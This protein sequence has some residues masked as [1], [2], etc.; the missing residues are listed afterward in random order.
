MALSL[1]SAACAIDVPQFLTAD[2]EPKTRKGGIQHLGFIKC[3][4]VF[5]DITD[6]AEWAAAVTAHDV[7]ITTEGVG[8]KPETS[9]TNIKLSS[10]RPETIS[11]ETHTIPFRTYATDLATETD[12]SIHN[13]VRNNI[14]KFRMFWIG[15][16]G[17][18]YLNP[19]YATDNAGFECSVSKWDYIVPEDSNE[20][21]Y[22]DIELTFTYVGIVAGKKLPNVFAELA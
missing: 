7:H 18:F 15:C 9:K 5:T 21:A 10:C 17:L 3:D 22:Y 14:G 6:E 19:D 2:C 13:Q 8:S 11:G 1:C 16:D 20:P 4:Y 12:F